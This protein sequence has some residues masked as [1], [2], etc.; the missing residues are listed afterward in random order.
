LKLPFTVE[1]KLPVSELS[2]SSSKDIE[3]EGIGQFSTN[4]RYLNV[5]LIISFLRLPR[6]L[7][8]VIGG[9]EYSCGLICMHEETY[10]NNLHRKAVTVMSSCI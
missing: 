5:F 3:L 10:R 1:R 8:R 9:T 4:D 2:V 6:R 7:Y